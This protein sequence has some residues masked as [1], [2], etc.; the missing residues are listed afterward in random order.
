MRFVHVRRFFIYF[1]DFFGINKRFLDFFILFGF[2]ILSS[3]SLP[4]FCP[5]YY[6]VDKVDYVPY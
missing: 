1:I 6:K 5:I 3:S 4:L 2:F